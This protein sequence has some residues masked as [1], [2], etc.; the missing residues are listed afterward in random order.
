MMRWVWVLLVIVAGPA[1]AQGGFLPN[2]P[3]P[4]SAVVPDRPPTVAVAPV[5]GVTQ[6]VPAGPEWVAMPGAELRA[7]DKQFARVSTLAL[8][9]GETVRFGAL[10]ITLRGC[11]MRPADRAADSAAFLE[12]TDGSG[13]PGFKGWM[14]VSAP[15]LGVLESATYDIRPVACRS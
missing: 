14:V 13:G 10:S 1:L 9:K 15:A 11:V 7:L 8:R 2:A 12:I 5:P 3:P 6:A 4:P